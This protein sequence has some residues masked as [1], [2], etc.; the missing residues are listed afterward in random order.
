MST[1]FGAHDASSGPDRQTERRTWRA[2]SSRI[3]RRRFAQVWGNIDEE[4]SGPTVRSRRAGMMR[5]PRQLGDDTVVSS[6]AIQ[7]AR[8]RRRASRWQIAAHAARFLRRVMHT[9]LMDARRSGASPRTRA[10]AAQGVAACACLEHHGYQ[11]CGACEC[12][13]ADNIGKLTRVSHQCISQSF[14]FAFDE[15]ETESLPTCCSARASQGHRVRRRRGQHAN[16]SG[17]IR[18]CGG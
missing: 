7:R 8:D 6:S 1:S 5:A 2:A 13:D 15:E 17:K 11:R 14:E 4:C 3:I 18:A 9:S 12:R 16:M 10:P